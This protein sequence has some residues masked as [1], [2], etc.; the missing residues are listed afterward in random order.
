MD[1]VWIAER[2]WRDGRKDFIG[3][4]SSMKKSIAACEQIE[5]TA[6]AFEKH[7]AYNYYECHLKSLHDYHV[8]ETEIDGRNTNETS[9]NE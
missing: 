1:K 9:E 8:F 5:G 3:V 6:L 2:D 4:F 7:E